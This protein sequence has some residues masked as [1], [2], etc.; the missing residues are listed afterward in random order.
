MGTAKNVVAV[1]LMVIG[2]VIGFCAMKGGNAISALFY[3]ADNATWVERGG[4]VSML[5]LCT[6]LILVFLR[7]EPREADKPAKPAEP[8]PAAPAAEAEKPAE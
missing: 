8:A 1:V 7:T 5:V 2:A 6:A 3:S 4:L